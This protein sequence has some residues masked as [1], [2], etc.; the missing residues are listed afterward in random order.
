MKNRILA[1][2]IAAALAVSLVT[3]GSF[4]EQAAEQ[5]DFVMKNGYVN[6]RASEILAIEGSFEYDTSKYTRGA[7]VIDTNRTESEEYNG[8]F[9]FHTGAGDK[10]TFTVDFGTFKAD[11]FSYMHYGG[12]A[13]PTE[14]DVFANGV[15]LGSGASTGGTGWLDLWEGYNGAMQDSF[16]INPPISGVQTIVIELTSSS[17][18]WPANAIGLFEF[19]DSAAYDPDQSV[20][21]EPDF[22]MTGDSLAINARKVLLKRGAITRDSEQFLTDHAIGVNSAS[23]EQ[24][25]FDGMF[26]IHGGA[27]DEF[28]FTVDFGEKSVDAMSYMSYGLAAESTDFDLFI[29]DELQGSGEGL[30]GNGWELEDYN[31]ANYDEF[32]FA[33]PV[34]GLCTVKIQITASSPAWPANNIGMFTFYEA[35][36]ATPTPEAA[37]T[38]EPSAPTDAPTKAPTAAPTDVP[39][40]DSATAPAAT[41]PEKTADNGGKTADNKPNAGLIA[42]ISIGAAVLVAAVVIAIVVAGKKKKAK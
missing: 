12:V 6:P 30:G 11:K 36:P 42:G 37:V 3:I 7:V 35:A 22:V 32:K 15:K 31:N 1:I 17:P 18:A 23:D 34:T 19:F 24:K 40:T 9:F 28:T 39:A 2:V 25:E 38:D 20:D 29:N 27:G 26:F 33:K 4:G 10:F 13:E 5:A 8:Q 14:F 41:A 21:N 16:E